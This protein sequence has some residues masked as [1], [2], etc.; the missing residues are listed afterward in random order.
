MKFHG[1]LSDF[2]WV[3]ELEIRIPDE[4]VIIINL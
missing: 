4:K 1:V 2:E 3:S